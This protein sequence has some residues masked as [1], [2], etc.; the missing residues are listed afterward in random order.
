M[1]MGFKTPVQLTEDKKAS[2]PIANTIDFHQEKK[3]IIKE[4]I[5]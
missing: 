2:L 1:I 3:G 4:F 5:L